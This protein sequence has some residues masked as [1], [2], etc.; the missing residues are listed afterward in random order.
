MLTEFA[1]SRISHQ[2]GELIN[3]MRQGKTFD[4]VIRTNKKFIS[5][6][7]NNNT[8]SFQSIFSFTDPDYEHIYGV[9][10]DAI[11]LEPQLH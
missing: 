8:D 3:Y 4:Y 1:E 9:Y 11:G 7:R 2:S 6:L 10:G 5:Y